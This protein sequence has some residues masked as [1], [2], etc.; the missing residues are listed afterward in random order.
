MKKI[1]GRW[2][3]RALTSAPKTLQDLDCPVDERVP[4]P[5]HAIAIEHPGVIPVEKKTMV[6]ARQA[7]ARHGLNWL[8]A[9]SVDPDHRRTTPPTT[10][11]ALCERFGLSLFY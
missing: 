10:L 11:A 8:L 6:V 1:H 7:S 9:K 2:E 4:V 3:A 5:E